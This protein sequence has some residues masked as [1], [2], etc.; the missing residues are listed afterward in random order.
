VRILFVTNMWPDAERPWYGTFIKTQADSLA[1]LGHEIDPLAIRGYA[2]KVEYARAI[3]EIRA[4][5]AGADLVHA[6]Y[7]H[8]AVVGRAQLSRPY[9]VSYCGDDV[10]GTATGDGGITPRSRVEA[11]VFRQLARVADATIT[12]SAEMEAALPAG[13]RARN[14]VIP[15]GVD[16]ERFAPG[17]RAATRYQLGWDADERAVL[18]VG[19][20][21]VAAKNHPLAEAVCAAAGEELAGI[22]L[23]VAWGFSPEQMP[24]L[25]S[26][27]D[28]LLFPSRSEGS[29]NAVKEALA[30]ELPVVATAVGDIPER[31]AGI[32][33]CFA[34]PAEVEPL[35]RALVGALRHGRVPE[36]RRAV[37]ELSLQRVA[38]RV[39]RVYEQAVARHG[40]RR[41]GSSRS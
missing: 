23:R 14:T 17:A 33:G 1:A 15:N 4:R 25:M 9:V 37:A 16:L 36:A 11:A 40:G 13:A 27:A 29:P 7:G 18:F 2:S 30:M 21:D 3:P 32:P 39:T 31:L 20:P 26:A 34:G 28:A 38:E 5:A 22:R 19:N 8:A 6:H 24:L 35:A 12:K 10:L 41:N